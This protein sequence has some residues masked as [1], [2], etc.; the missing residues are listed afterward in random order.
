MS[1]VENRIREL[2]LDIPPCPAAVASYVP[3]MKVAGFVY[4]SGQTPIIDGK[5]MYKGKLGRDFTTEQGYEAARIA[6]MRL[7]AELQSVVDDLDRVRIV[8]VTGYVNSDE[9]FDEHPQVVNGASELLLSVFGQRGPHS[10]TSVGVPSLPAGAAV[11]VDLIAY[12]D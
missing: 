11:E 6:A 1:R 7:I 4:A 8:R 12:V 3:A 2:G 5:L 10:R 9:D